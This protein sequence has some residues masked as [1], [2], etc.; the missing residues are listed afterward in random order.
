MKVHQES[1]GF[2]PAALGLGLSSAW[3]IL[4]GKH[5]AGKPATLF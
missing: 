4:F 1:Q 2:I 5:K 3:S